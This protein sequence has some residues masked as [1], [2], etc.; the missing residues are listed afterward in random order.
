M[1]ADSKADVAVFGVIL[2]GTFADFYA[3]HVAV[4]VGGIVQAPHQFGVRLTRLQ[5]DA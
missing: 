1:V 3:I 2:Q 4:T 5:G